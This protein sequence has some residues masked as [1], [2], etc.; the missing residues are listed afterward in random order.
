M[1]DESGLNP[2]RIQ[3]RIDCQGIPA[4]ENIFSPRTPLTIYIYIYTQTALVDG[5]WIDLYRQNAQSLAT[6]C[7]D[8]PIRSTVPPCTKSGGRRGL[9]EPYPS[10]FYQQL[11]GLHA[12]GKRRRGQNRAIV[13]TALPQDQTPPLLRLAPECRAI[14]H[15]FN[16]GAQCPAPTIL[17]DRTAIRSCSSCGVYRCR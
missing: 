17:R 12:S 5:S 6:R 7:E 1:S 10:R 2:L 11:A 14:T 4:L 8:R 13:A 3:Y 15:F 16:M 9:S